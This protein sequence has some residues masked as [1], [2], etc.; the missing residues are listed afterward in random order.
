[1]GLTS[2]SR[3]VGA[4][5]LVPAEAALTGAV[6]RFGIRVTCVSLSFAGLSPSFRGRTERA[7]GVAAWVND[8]CP[9]GGVAGRGRHP[10]EPGTPCS[11]CAQW[12]C[13]AWEPPSSSHP[14]ELCCR[15]QPCS[16]FVLWVFSAALNPGSN[17]LF[18]WGCCPALLTRL[19]HPVHAGSEIAQE[20]HQ[21]LC[22]TPWGKSKEEECVNSFCSSR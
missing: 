9:W 22:F 11:H 8:T 18:A 1:M 2:A 19:K 10:Q 17:L 4:H 20:N 21:G 16:Q 3:E 13:L 6:R 14:A 7:V 5:R 12:P 15:H